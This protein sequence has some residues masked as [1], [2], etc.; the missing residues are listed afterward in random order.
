MIKGV[1]SHDN[2][3]RV[4]VLPV[5]LARHTAEQSGIRQAD[6]GASPGTGPPGH[7]HRPLQLAYYT[8]GRLTDV[9]L[10]LRRALGDCEKYLG[11]DHQ[12]TQTVRENLD[13]ATQA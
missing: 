4:L 12:M 5:G 7:P 3:K 2:S 1:P 6:R 8:A 13:A 10:V 9:V 11:P